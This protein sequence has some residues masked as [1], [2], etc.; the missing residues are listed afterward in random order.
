MAYFDHN[1]T[2][3]VSVDVEEAVVS[4]LRDFGNPSSV[5]AKG[6]AAR[7]I[8]ENAREE[9]AD[10]VGGLPE[11]VIFTS[12]ATEANNQALLCSGRK[13]V[14]ASAIEHP[15]VLEISPGDPKISVGANGVVELE[16]LS[17]IL[18]RRG[19]F[20]VVSVMA[21]NNE[22]G[23]IQPV[24]GSAECAHAAGALFHCDAVQAVGRIPIDMK[25]LGVDMLT[26]SAHKL[27][28]PKGA[29]ALIL[30]EG[31][32]IEAFIQGGGQERSH[33]GGTENVPG[34]AGFGVAVREARARRLSIG[35][36]ANL[37]GV[38]ERRAVAAVPDAV[39]FGEDA[40]R[41]ANTSMLA[42]PGVDAET[43]IM[44]LDLAGIEV[45]AGAAC[46]S[47]KVGESHVLQAMGVPDELGRCGIRISIGAENTVEE[48]DKFIEVWSGLRK[49]A[50]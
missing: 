49:R 39:I 34:I 32:E 9:I 46:S 16:S 6:R 21:A 5:H 22:S 25:R 27:G 29:G 35:R 14:I 30:G 8:V 41:I 42:L 48:V 7:K 19:R 43:Q 2:S 13:Q 10:L 31:V 47:G 18:R 37:I 15:S 17:T 1:A 24:K 50:A 23:V 20:A 40:P 28:G 12:G 4:A 33:R 45:S 11:N 36:I 3:P 26:I 44:A 38:L